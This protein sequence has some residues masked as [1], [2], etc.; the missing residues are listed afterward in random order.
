[1]VRIAGVGMHKF[2][3]FPDKSYIDL[4]EEAIRNALSDAGVS[5]RDAEVLFHGNALAG[6]LTGSNIMKRMG[7]NGAPIYNLEAYCVSSLAGLTQASDLIEAGTYDLAVVVGTEVQPRGYIPSP[8]DPEWVQQT[9]MAV[10][11]AKGDSQLA[12]RYMDLHGMTEEQI[13]KVGV[14]SKR[15]G[16]LTPYSHYQNADI[17]VDDV[18]DSPM[19]NT[20]IRL[21]E[22]SPPS[23][24][25]AAV[26]VCSD[27]MAEELGVEGDVSLDAIAQGSPTY[28]ESRYPYPYSPLRKRCAETVYEETGL[29]PDDMDFAQLHDATAFTEIECYE[30]VGF[31]EEGEGPTLIENEETFLDGSIPVNT[32]GGMMSRGNAP[33]ALGLASVAESVWQ[34]RGEADERQV[35]G[36]EHGL[37]TLGG[38]GPHAVSAILSA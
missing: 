10:L 11:P 15:N 18:L 2:G 1:M 37:I 5:W 17:T 25:G 34:L 14:K 21:Y 8:G 16:A 27:E 30:N 23:D 32:D 6:P 13:A 4:A 24:G 31:A 26:V 3:K 9:G 22:M 35:D 7:H 29:G 20:P 38:Y 36:A 33:G 19:V 12:Q 28:E